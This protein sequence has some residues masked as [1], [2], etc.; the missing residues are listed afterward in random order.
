MTLIYQKIG[1]I[2]GAIMAFLLQVFIILQHIYACYKKVCYCRAVTSL[3][4][5]Y[6]R[7]GQKHWGCYIYVLA[8]YLKF[9]LL[10]IQYIQKL[11][12]R[13]QVFPCYGPVL[14]A[15]KYIVCEA[16]VLEQDSHAMLCCKYLALFIIRIFP[17]HWRPKLPRPI[18]WTAHL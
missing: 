1:F 3:S 17:W 8:T 2:D 14:H 5:K 4:Q 6:W 15:K 9:S 16:R 7:L 12:G 18:L 11:G 13:G 10:N